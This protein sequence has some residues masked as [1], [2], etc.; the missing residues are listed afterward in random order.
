[1]AKVSQGSIRTRVKA[2]GSRT[3]YPWATGYNASDYYNGFAGDL[4]KPIDRIQ[5]ELVNCPGHHVM[6]RVSLVGSSGYLPWVTDLTDFAGIDGRQ[7]DK[8]QVKIV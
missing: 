4:G 1:M 2:I 5:F 7:I 6:Y 3:Y 8:I